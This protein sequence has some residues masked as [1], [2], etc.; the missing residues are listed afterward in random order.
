[1]TAPEVYAAPLPAYDWEEP[2]RL[3]ENDWDCSVESI[4]WCMFSWGRAPDDNWL[5]ETMIAEGV[6]NPDIGCT[7]ASGAGLASFVNRHYGEDGYVA[8]NESTTTFDVLAAEASTHSHPIAIGG[9]GW[10]HWSGLR[11]YDAQADALVL[12][13]PAPG[14]YGIQQTMSRTQFQQLGPFSLVRVTHPESEASNGNGQSPAV[15]YPAGIDVSSHQG[16]VDWAA[17]AASGLSFSFAKSSG[18]AVYR[19]PYFEAAWNGMRAAGIQ[20]GAYHFAFEPSLQPLPGPGPETEAEYFLDTVLPLGLGPGDMLVLDIEAGTGDLGDWALRF[21][22]YVE[23]IVGFKPLIYTA[24]WFSE[25]HG[26][27]GHPDLAQYGLWQAAYQATPPAPCRPWSA[28][29]FWQYTDSAQVPGVSTPCDRNLFH[30]SPEDLP[31]WGNPS[32]LPPQPPPDD[33]HKWDGAVGSGL[34]ELMAQDSTLP[35]QKWST[36]LPLGAPPPADIEQC[37]GQN[38][39][40]YSWS[41]DLNVGW[42]HRPS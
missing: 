35:S 20:R 7:D 23:H 37:M 40:I 3:Q 39:V 28:F 1:L 32:G 2:P 30:G 13:N 16:M 36:W 11:S 8:R 41:L 14:W 24:A 42:R 17:A 10:Y 18:G 38:G 21:C 22:R 34:L 9:R 5:E 12:A 15:P 27:P 19:N 26:F 33:I 31:R 29:T 25:P 4:E 6:A